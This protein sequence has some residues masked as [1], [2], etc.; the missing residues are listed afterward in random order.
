MPLQPPPWPPFSSRLSDQAPLEPSPSFLHYLPPLPYCGLTKSGV[1]R[2]HS[3]LST[4]AKLRGGCM[5]AH[6]LFTAETVSLLLCH[7]SISPNAIHLPASGTTVLNL[8]ASPGHADIV[9]LLLEQEDID[10]T[11]RQ[12]WEDMHRFTHPCRAGRP[13][14]VGANVRIESLGFEGTPIFRRD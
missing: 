3:N 6:P 11:L 12:Q 13:F 10:D 8:A 1:D 7:N 9:N 14:E 4:F 5:R 2:L